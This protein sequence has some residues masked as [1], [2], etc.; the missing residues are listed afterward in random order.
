M[1]GDP[2]GTCLK[3]LTTIG[4]SLTYRAA[5]LNRPIWWTSDNGCGFDVE[6]GRN[7]PL[8]SIR[9]CVLTSMAQQGDAVNR[10]RLLSAEMEAQH[11]SAQGRCHG[12]SRLLCCLALR[13]G[14]V[15]PRL[16]SMTRRAHPMDS[17]ARAEQEPMPVGVRWTARGPDA[18]LPQPAG[19]TRITSTFAAPR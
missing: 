2:P 13:V 6:G 14:R 4:V 5:S 3:L 7:P 15:C 12:P 8:A 19:P 16:H 18:F 10:G 1:L 11:W 9:A 17:R